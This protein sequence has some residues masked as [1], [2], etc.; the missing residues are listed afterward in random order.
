MDLTQLIILLIALFSLFISI[1]ANWRYLKS[2]FAKNLHVYILTNDEAKPGHSF[3]LQRLINTNIPVNDL[4]SANSCLLLQL[5]VRNSSYKNLT[6]E[7]VEAYVLVNGDWAET[8]PYS[9]IS[10]RSD[11]ASCSLPEKR[12]DFEKESVN[13]EAYTEKRMPVAFTFNTNQ[14]FEKVKVEIR[15]KDSENKWSEAQA[16]IPRSV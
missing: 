5:K 2:F 12:P 14:S 13:I 1:M 10:F 3:L 16:S 11:K 4:S 7:K 6:L 15:I 9:G 8:A